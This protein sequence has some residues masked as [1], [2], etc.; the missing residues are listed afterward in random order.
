MVVPKDNMVHQIKDLVILT[1]V[2][3][4]LKPVSIM[5]VMQCQPYRLRLFL[6]NYLSNK[7]RLDRSTST[8]MS[9][10]IFEEVVLWRFEPPGA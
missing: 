8:G 5:V 9:I 2:L 6:W 4:E 7:R 3:E 10:Y 1:F